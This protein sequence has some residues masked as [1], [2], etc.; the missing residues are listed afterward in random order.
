MNVALILAGGV[1]SRFGAT[2]PKQFIEVCGKPVLAY[3]IEAF[4]N[5][6]EIDAIIIACVKPYIDYVWE[7]KKEY[8]LSKLKWIT[9]GGETFQESVLNG[10]RYLEDKIDRD[11]IV[12]VHFGASPFVTAD[13]IT[14][15]IRV[16]E[17]KGNAISSTDFYVLSGKKNTTESVANPDNY[18]DEYIDRE[19]IA[20][21]NSPH[22]FKYGFIDGLYKEAISTGAI[23]AVE[24][25]TT[26]LMYALGKK[27][28]FAFGSQNNIKITQKEDLRLFEGYV[29]ERQRRES[30]CVSGD[31]VVALAEGFEECEALIVVDILRR[32]GISVVTASVADTREVTSSRNITIIADAMISD[33]DFDSSLMFFLPGGRVGV[34]HLEK[35]K[36]VNEQC[37]LFARDRYLAA[38]CAAPCI[39]AKYGLLKGKKATCHPDY[40]RKMVGV[41][42]I[43]ESVDVDGRIITGQG[44][45]ASFQFAFELLKALGKGD[46][47]A[48]LKTA[49]CF[50]QYAAQKTAEERNELKSI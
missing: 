37:R 28:Y 31:V 11:D 8:G 32:A 20:V 9:E 49:A 14:D 13:I 6:V 23:N 12:L 16:C 39:L 1:G 29:I 43:H 40:E 35:N 45:G 47:D 4:Q 36:V 44:L 41:K 21:M 2:I 34:K 38:I 3:T 15:C 7:L 5:H 10:V 26:T 42:I 30:Q 22:A 27:V 24:P 50:P 19:T 17:K 46:C 18:S 33:V 48:Q 25:H